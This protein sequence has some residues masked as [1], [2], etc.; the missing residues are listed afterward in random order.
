ME[1]SYQELAESYRNSHVDVAKF[2]A[3]TERDFSAAEFGLQ[4]FPTLVMLPRSSAAVIRY[5]SETRDAKTLDMW[6]TALA[7]KE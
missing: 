4:T 6:V 7:G 2:R 1:E 5:P 3:D